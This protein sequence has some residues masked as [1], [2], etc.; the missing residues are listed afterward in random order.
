[1][2]LTLSSRLVYGLIVVSPGG[3]G[4]MDIVCVHLSLDYRDVH[5]RF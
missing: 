3:V 5:V 2:V 1:M 4:E